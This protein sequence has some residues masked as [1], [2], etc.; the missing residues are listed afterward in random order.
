MRKESWK[1]G[2]SGAG[3]V[4]AALASIATSPAEWS[5]SDQVGVHDV[6]LD[7]DQPE[8]VRHFRVRSSQQHSVSVSGKIHWD[9]SI[10]LPVAAVRVQILSDDG[11]LLREEIERAADAGNGDGEL[12]ETP[13]HARASSAC[14]GKPCEEV[15]YT[16]KLSMVDGHPNESV[17]IDYDFVAA[18]AGSGADEP[19]DAFVTVHQD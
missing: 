19:S 11:S 2:L 7:T 13:L 9:E 3:L 14:A 18:I 15:G 16:V 1:Q 10:S 5:L 8:D 12:D 17:R 4:L 6:R